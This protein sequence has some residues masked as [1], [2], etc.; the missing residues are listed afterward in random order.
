MSDCGLERP[1]GACLVLAAAQARLEGH[2]EVP[3]PEAA[4]QRHLAFR[5]AGLQVERVGGQGPGA[6]AHA[7]GLR[8]PHSGAAQ[9]IGTERKRRCC[10]PSH[11]GLLRVRRGCA[12]PLAARQGG[13]RELLAPH[14][15][16]G[17]EGRGAPACAAAAGPPAACSAGG[18]ANR[19][20]APRRRCGRGP[21]RT[22]RALAQATPR[23]RNPLPFP[24]M[25]S[26]LRRP[27][28]S[29]C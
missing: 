8:A 14:G 27:T 2:R 20:A 19:L 6:A 24:Q 1:G 23:S 25:G 15:C 3:A 11:A 4:G 9:R 10:P 22:H 12:A 29:A 28:S 18:W 13:A 7:G 5:V 16:A 21:A 17:G 26:R